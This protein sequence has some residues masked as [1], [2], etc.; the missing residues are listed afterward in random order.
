[1]P[2]AARKLLELIRFSHTIFAL[3]FALLAAALAW[4]EEPFRAV[5]LVGILLCMVFARSAA[6]AFNRLADRHID[7]RN[8]RTAARHLPAGTLSAAAVWGF[9]L[10]CCAGFVASTLL[11]AYRD[12]PN[13]WPLYLCGP[14]LLF[15]LGYSLA[16][17][18]TS[19]AHLWLGVALMLA[20]VAAW[21]AVKG[22]TDL[23]VPLILGAA[24][25]FWV[26]G[27]DI[28][29]A[30]QDADF[31]RA[32]GLHSVPS[33]FGVPASL[34]IAAASHAV[35]FGLLVWLGFASPHLGWVY[36]V[37][38]A[39]AG[40]LLVYEHRLVRPDDLTR[41]NR[42]FFHVNGVISVGLLVLVL[43]QLA[44]R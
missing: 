39:A 6:M 2:T 25:A 38:L 22:L 13:Q 12:P 3:P 28:L 34:R 24:V 15:L 8:P 33:R 44:V 16:K 29:Y 7:A 23:T 36:A 5:D 40:G 37:G 10:A 1:M 27:F 35:M 43:I 11:F 32:A 19:L 42:A 30:C 4:A 21:I 20:P 26:A 18:F 31:D 41:V 14:V 9:T 17:R